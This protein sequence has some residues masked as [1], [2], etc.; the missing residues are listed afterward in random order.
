MN[1]WLI[2][3]P[4]WGKYHTDT[5]IRYALP[6]LRKVT[7]DLDVQLM[8]HTDD[9]SKLWKEMAGLPVQFRPLEVG[10]TQHDTFG[11]C[12][13][14]VL[15]SAEDG[16]Y[17]MLL[18][19]D[20]VVSK[21]VMI[22]SEL[23][24][25]QGKKLI[26]AA[27]SRCLLRKDNKPPMGATAHQLLDWTF[28]CIHPSVA[29][30]Y[31]GTGHTMVP[32]AIYFK[33]E[34]GVVLRGFHLHP[35]A[36][37]KSPGLTLRG[38]TLDEYICDEFDTKDIYVVT[39]PDE[40]SLAELSPPDRLFKGLPHVMTPKSVYQWAQHRTTARHRWL[41]ESRIVLQGTGE[42]TTDIEPCDLILNKLKFA[43]D[44][45]YN[46]ELPIHFATEEM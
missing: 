35:L 30:C 3:I 33:S 42:D 37:V 46:G 43:R 18:T 31:W 2:S 9:A 32:W 10:P 20:M 5:L 17:I 12:H 39:S 15:A 25:R 23:R 26:I 7:C 34:H 16:Q 19:A 14:D 22:A 13:R 8:V 21:E 24:F 1:K 41:F 11:N 36:M 40:L 28:T 45:Y 4:C 44:D 29:D 38:M 6:A 27:A